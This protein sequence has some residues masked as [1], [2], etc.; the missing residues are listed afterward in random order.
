MSTITRPE[1]ISSAALDS[2]WVR[3]QFPSLKLNVNG[4]PAVFLDG[5][6]GTQVPQRVIDAITDYLLYRNANNCGQFLTSKRTDET[7]AAAHA[8]MRSEEHTSELQSHS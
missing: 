5:P 2:A 8:A 3:A 4:Q 1:P 6:A 7:I